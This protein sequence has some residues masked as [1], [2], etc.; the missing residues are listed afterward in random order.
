MIDLHVIEIEPEVRRRLELLPI[1]HHR[2]V[3]EYAE[4]L[5]TM[6]V[7]TPMPFARPLRNG[8]YEL[9][10][11]FDGQATRVTYWFAPEHRIVL[12]T[13]FR[14]TRIHE[15]NQVVRAVAARTTCEN[16]HDPAH[17]SY[18]RSDKNEKSE[19]GDAS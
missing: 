7:R 11:T 1:K 13:V 18:D 4:L 16:E 19:E 9:R 2:K 17:L 14:K 6:G 5:A 15:E 10:P 3:E 12:L 8:V